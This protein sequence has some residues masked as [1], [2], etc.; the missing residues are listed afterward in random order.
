MILQ[1]EYL[2]L[3][4]YNNS[5]QLRILFLAYHREREREKRAMD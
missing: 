3:F 4:D 2:V 1:Q 5:S